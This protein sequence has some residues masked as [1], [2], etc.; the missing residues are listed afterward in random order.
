M[1][2]T[3]VTTATWRRLFRLDALLALA[4]ANAAH[5]GPTPAPTCTTGASRCNQ[6]V[7]EVCDADHS[8][9]A[10]M[11]CTQVSADSG[12]TFTCRDTEQGS[13]CKAEASPGSDGGGS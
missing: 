7:V 1:R 13:T 4:M 10:S 3:T 9:R 2:A 11:S 5:C 8:W 12:K 6:N